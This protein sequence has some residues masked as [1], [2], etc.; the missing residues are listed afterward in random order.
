MCSGIKPLVCIMVIAE[1]LKESLVKTKCLALT[2]VVLVICCSSFLLQA[3]TKA[4][5]KIAVTKGQKIA[6]L[7]DSI[8]AAGRA[9]GGYCQLVLSALNKQG[10]EVTGVFAGIGG[11][12]SNQM[13]GA[14]GVLRRRQYH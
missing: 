12:K 11:H 2:C 13:L 6:F 4:P 3:E 9:K 7:G 8:T 5:G 14:L 10:L 1:L